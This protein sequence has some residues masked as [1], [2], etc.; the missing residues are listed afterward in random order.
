MPRKS[1]PSFKLKLIIWDLAATMGTDNYSAI[2]RDLD[3]KLEELRKNKN[4]DFTEDVPDLRTVR[5]IVE[6]DI[7][8]IS[9]EAVVANLPRHVWRLRKDY[10]DIKRLAENI[11]APQQV[12]PPTAAPQ[13]TP[14]EKPEIVEPPSK[15]TEFADDNKTS[16]TTG[17]E[18]EPSKE[19]ENSGVPPVSPDINVSEA[20]QIKNEHSEQDEKPPA[21]ANPQAGPTITEENKPGSSSSEHIETGPTTTQSDDNEQSKTANKEQVPPSPEEKS[22]I[23]PASPDGIDVN[24][25]KSWGVPLEKRA[26]I[27]SKWQ[28]WHKRGRHDI[29]QAFPR[30]R[31]DLM[32]RKIPYKIA[33]KLLKGD[34]R[35]IEFHNDEFHEAIAQSR[36]LRP[37]EHSESQWVFRKEMREMHNSTYRVNQKH[38]DDIDGLVKELQSTVVSSRK[39]KKY[40][41]LLKIEQDPVFEVLQWHCF[42][43][44]DLF[45]TLKDDIK[46]MERLESETTQAKSN[47]SQGNVDK[48]ITG[49][50]RVIDQTLKEKSHLKSRCH[51]CFLHPKVD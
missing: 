35:A 17:K 29:C 37:W 7:N 43:I 3:Y 20:S 40:E 6:Q 51:L 11:S 24:I 36:I 8:K 45:L 28:R 44:H 12:P 26:E 22:S 47:R 5:R 21:D 41:D 48:S 31:Q 32:E 16:P 27:I 18:A 9:P 2:Q 42:D 49:L 39:T 50:Q 33:E 1:P 14:E 38:L 13:Q 10:E 15:F 34:I 23:C 46:T 19:H 4:E 25:L 30:L